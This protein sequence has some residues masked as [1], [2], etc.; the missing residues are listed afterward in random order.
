MLLV[1]RP[2]HVINRIK[3]RMEKF[4]STHKIRE[5]IGNNERVSKYRRYRRHNN[6]N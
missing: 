4:K 1:F 5:K 3:L 6:Y 2:V